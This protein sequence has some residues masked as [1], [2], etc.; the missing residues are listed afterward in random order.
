M[1]AELLSNAWLL[2]WAVGLQQRRHRLFMLKGE[3]AAE[4]AQLASVSPGYLCV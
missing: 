3:V 2:Q 1:E 4:Y